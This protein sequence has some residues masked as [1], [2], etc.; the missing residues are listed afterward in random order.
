M[1]HGEKDDEGRERHQRRDQY[2][3]KTI[4]DAKKHELPLANHP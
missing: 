2:L 3:L 1:H 4:E